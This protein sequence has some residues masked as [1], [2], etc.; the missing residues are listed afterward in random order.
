MLKT[1]DFILQ[2]KKKKSFEA[3]GVITSEGGK[4]RGRK[5]AVA[6]CKRVT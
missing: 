5:V 2:S 1:L 6:T 4:E 3:K